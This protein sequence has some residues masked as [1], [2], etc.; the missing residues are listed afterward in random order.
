[1]ER[2]GRGTQNIVKWCKEAGLP[3][4]KWSAD[5]SGIT[6]TLPTKTRTAALTLN[7]RE[8]RLLDELKPGE[9]LRLPEYAGRLA[10]SERQGRRDLGGLVEGGWLEREGEGPATIFRRSRKAWEP[11]RPGQTRPQ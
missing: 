2:V 5:A 7:L 1:M 4:P 9:T 10:V 6:L 11:A 8:R 3:Q